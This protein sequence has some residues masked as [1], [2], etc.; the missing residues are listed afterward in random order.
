MATLSKNKIKRSQQKKIEDMLPVM[1]S[2]PSAPCEVWA[3]NAQLPRIRPLS[4]R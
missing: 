2:A 4:S 1:C 3:A